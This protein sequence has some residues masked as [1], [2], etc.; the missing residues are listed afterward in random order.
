MMS[1]IQSRGYL[2]FSKVLTPSTRTTEIWTVRNN[3]VN[4]AVEL[5]RIKWHSKWRRYCLFPNDGTIWDS[6]CLTTVTKFI[7]DL[8]DERRNYTKVTL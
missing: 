1:D 6:T 2:T 4:T 3:V 8:M 5:G 7:K